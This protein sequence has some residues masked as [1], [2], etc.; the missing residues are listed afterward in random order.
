MRTKSKLKIPSSHSPSI[1]FPHIKWRNMEWGLWLVHNASS[2]P[3]THSYSAP[4]P[5]GVPLTGC[6]PSQT[7]PAWASLRLQLSKSCSSMAPY[8]RV[9]PS[10]TAPQGSTRAAAPS[11][12]QPNSRLL[13]MGCSSGLVCSLQG[14]FMGCTSFTHCPQMHCGLLHGYTWRSAPHDAHGLQGDSL[15][16]HDPLLGCR[17]LLLCNWNTSCLLLNWPWGLQFLTPFSQL[18]FYSIFSLS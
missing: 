7:D 12:L 10:D 11:V 16:L 4:A 18:L 14:F 8:H 5:C 13:L 1:S 15:L 2:L 17:E 3:H 6:H 9:H